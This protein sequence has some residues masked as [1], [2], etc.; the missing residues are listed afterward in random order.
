MIVLSFGNVVVQSDCHF[1]LA[2]DI[3]SY[4]SPTFIYLMA[5]GSIP[6]QL[7]IICSYRCFAKELLLI[8]QT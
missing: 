8:M 1:L 7:W 6:D 5:R 3:S 4:H 2:A